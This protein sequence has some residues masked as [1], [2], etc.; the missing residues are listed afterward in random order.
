MQAFELSAIDRRRLRDAKSY[1]EFLRVPALSIGL[2]VLPPGGVDPQKPHAEDEVY[3]VI[4]GQGMIRIGDEDREV[5]AGSVV[6]APAKMPHRFHSI[7][8]ELQILVFFAPAE[9]TNA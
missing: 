7:T 4:R 9:G 3:Y 5:R 8:E 6:L 2:Y 1:V